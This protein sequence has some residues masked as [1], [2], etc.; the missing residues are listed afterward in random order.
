MKKARL[1]DVWL[2]FVYK[3]IRNKIGYKIDKNYPISVSCKL[4]V[5]AKNIKMLCN[6]PYTLASYILEERNLLGSVTIE[7]AFVEAHENE[8]TDLFYVID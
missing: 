2:V 4:E 6:N 5:S 3:P 7:D 1:F 8:N